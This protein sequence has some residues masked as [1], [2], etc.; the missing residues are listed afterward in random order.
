MPDK[1]IAIRHGC[2]LFR[3]DLEGAVAAL[4]DE[5][6]RLI[7]AIC[8]TSQ[9]EQLNDRRVRV[10]IH[11]NDIGDLGSADRARMSQAPKDACGRA[12]D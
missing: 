7:L 5:T 9:P 8:N 6:T 10:R 2:G 3:A 12:R 4:I 11:R 1:R